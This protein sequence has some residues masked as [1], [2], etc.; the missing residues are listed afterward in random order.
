M[1]PEEIRNLI[2]LKED[3]WEYDFDT[4][5]YAF[6]LG[7]DVIEDDIVKDAFQ[8]GVM[9]STIKGLPLESIKEMSFE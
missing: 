6:A 4:N 9:G 3:Y 2:S 1:T 7:L 8:L 5:C